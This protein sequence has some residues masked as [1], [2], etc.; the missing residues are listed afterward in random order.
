MASEHSECFPLDLDGVFWDFKCLLF[1]NELW[2]GHNGEAGFVTV[3]NA[4][5][6]P[7]KQGAGGVSDNTVRLFHARQRYRYS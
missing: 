6:W 2:N 3:D 5:L 7:V 4:H 1:R